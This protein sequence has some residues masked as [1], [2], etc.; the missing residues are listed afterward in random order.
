MAQYKI[1]IINQKPR[2]SECVEIHEYDNAPIFS[3]SMYDNTVASMF[4]Y[5]AQSVD[6]RCLDA[7]VERDGE[8]ILHLV[9]DTHV[10][11]STIYS[12]LKVARPREKYRFIRTMTVAD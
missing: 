3:K 2:K 8:K 10:D 6:Y 4:F 7:T 9:M 1:T 11:G 12:I 5:A